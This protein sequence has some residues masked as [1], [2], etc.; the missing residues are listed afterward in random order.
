MF[1]ILIVSGGL[2]S[3]A[4][5][6]RFS[7][8]AVEAAL[9]QR[10]A[11]VVHIELDDSLPKMLDSFCPDV[12]L[13]L[14]DMADSELRS[15]LEGIPCVYMSGD[16][17]HEEPVGNCESRVIYAGILGFP[18]L[19]ALAA[20]AVTALRTIINPVIAPKSIFGIAAKAGGIPFEDLC[21]LLVRQAAS[22]VRGVVDIGFNKS[23][24]GNLLSN[25][26]YHP[27]VL[28]NVSCASVEGVLQAVKYEDIE[29]Q[30][31]VCALA[32]KQAKLRGSERNEIWKGAQTLWWKGVPMSRSGAEYQEFLDR[33]FLS[34]FAQS[35]EF[36]GALVAT[37][38][39]ILTHSYGLHDPTQTVLTEYEFVTRLTFLRQ[40]LQQQDRRS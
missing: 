13:H 7:G 29:Q 37:G 9:K 32:D 8:N 6:S 24:P 3:D 19:R 31:S 33:L 5:V 35:D 11:H 21:W 15:Y 25:F 12:A 26:A 30:V 16:L 36:K 22:R 28:D 4:A 2:C 27:F 23:F 38:R 14:C 34:V 17:Y 39:K 1:R 20:G 10:F 40:Y 18:E